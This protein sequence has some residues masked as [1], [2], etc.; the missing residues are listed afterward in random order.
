MKPDARV[1]DVT[2]TLTGDRVGMTI[3]EN[4]L[5]HIMAVLTDL[6]SDPEMAVI[7]EYSTNAYDAHIEI[8]NIAP[9]EVTLPSMLSPFLKIRDY[10]V[11]MDAE[12][13]RLTYSRYGASTKRS[14]ND[15]VG[16]LGLGCKSALTY[17]NQFTL[18]GIKNG[19]RTQV[20]VSRDEDGTGSMTIVDQSATDE[21]NGVEVIVPVKSFNRFSEK[22]ARFFAFWQPGSVLV[23]GEQPKR[24]DG[25]WLA[26]DLLMTT[27]SGQDYVVMGNVPYP[28]ESNQPYSSVVAFVEIGDVHFTPSRESL[29]MTKTTKDTIEKIIARIMELRGPAMQRKIDEATNRYEA[30]KIIQRA[31]EVGLW[32]A[33]GDIQPVY[34]GEEIPLTLSPAKHEGENEEGVQTEIFVVVPRH[35]RYRQKSFTNDRYISIEEWPKTLWFSNYESNGFTATR[36]AKLEQWIDQISDAGTDFDHIEYFVLTKTP[37]DTK[38]IDPSTIFNWD[39][40]QSQK[41]PRKDKRMDGRPKGSY[42]AY[43]GGVY[44]GEL[45]ADE[46]IVSNG[47]FWADHYGVAPRDR[48]ILLSYYPDCTIVLLSANRI[49]KFQRDFPSAEPVIKKRNEIA[50]EWVNS[51][52]PMDLVTLHIHNDTYLRQSLKQ[53]DP[54]RVTDEELQ[55]VVRIAYA[56]P[57]GL[58]TRYEEFGNIVQLPSAFENPLNKYPLLHSAGRYGRMNDDE[59]EHAYLYINAV[60]AVKETN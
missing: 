16:M 29:Q 58:V 49:N 34:N 35:K 32:R 4:S 46:I 31:R 53:F 40:V 24:I 2:S 6:Y 39:V 60:H 8:G 56:T 50:N 41:L 9:I 57:N 15:Q 36:R 11:C 13:I 51:L 30:I 17:T 42:K 43:V 28:F 47:V 12:D 33:V 52:T 26:D 44:T 20:S 10:G 19:V 23:N 45:Q 27:E 25:L 59:L 7:R 21:P 1:L 14:T 55:Q 18:T 54:A 37:P 3:D 38:W 5:A 48:N 22:A